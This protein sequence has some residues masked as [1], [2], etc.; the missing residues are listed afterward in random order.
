MLHGINLGPTDFTQ[1][2]AKQGCLRPPNIGKT[3]T[4]SLIS[5][6]R[7]ILAKK[8]GRTLLYATFSTVS[9]RCHPQLCALRTF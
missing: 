9:R 3:R 2:R 8:T 5:E 7:C 4:F 1:L 6:E